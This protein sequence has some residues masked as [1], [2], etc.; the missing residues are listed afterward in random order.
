[1]IFTMGERKT[2]FE[3][4]GDVSKWGGVGRLGSSWSHGAVN[5]LKS[6]SN[7]KSQASLHSTT[8]AFRPTTTLGRF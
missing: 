2:V 3:K 7:F 6:W 8:K 1:M 4:K 5:G